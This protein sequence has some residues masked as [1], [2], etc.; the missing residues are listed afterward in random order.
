MN[1]LRVIGNILLDTL[2]AIFGTALLSSAI[3][4]LVPHSGADVIWRVWIVSTVLASLLGILAARYRAA[5]TEVWAWLIPAGV[6]A[7]RALLYA[8]GRRTGLVTRFSGYDCAIGLQKPDCTDF[9]AFTV[10]F[11]R[12]AAY[13]TAAL[14]TLRISGWLTKPRG[15]A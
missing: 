3:P 8:F 13:S 14:V 5:G 11:I 4:H 1:R 2:A 9:F 10:P 12:G 15:T 7:C 6:F